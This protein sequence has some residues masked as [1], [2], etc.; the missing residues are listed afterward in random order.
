M[1]FISIIDCT[2]DKKEKDK[3]KFDKKKRHKIFYIGPEKKV[4]EKI[5]R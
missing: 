1:N 5:N 4:K 2:I 3:N